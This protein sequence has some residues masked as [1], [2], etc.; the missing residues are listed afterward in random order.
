MGKKAVDSSTAIVLSSIFFIF[1]IVDTVQ[2]QT[3]CFCSYQVS[4]SFKPMFLLF[5]THPSLNERMPLNPFLVHHDSGQPET[6][7]AC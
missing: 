4:V 6:T 5:H 2:S 7:H 3:K 1:L